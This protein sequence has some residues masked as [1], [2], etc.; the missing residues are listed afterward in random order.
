MSPA[1]KLCPPLDLHTDTI[2]Q[3]ENDWTIL[4]QSREAARGIPGS[5]TDRMKTD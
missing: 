3:D 2:S 4:N 5:E 1:R